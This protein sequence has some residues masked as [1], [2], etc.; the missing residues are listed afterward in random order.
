MDVGTR[1]IKASLF[2]M[3]FYHLLLNGAPSLGSQVPVNFEGQPEPN[4]LPRPRDV[5]RE[6]LSLPSP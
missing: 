5:L 4:P 6:F 2:S 3:T 1:D